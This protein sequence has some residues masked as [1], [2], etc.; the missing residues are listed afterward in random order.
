LTYRQ[1]SFRFEERASSLSIAVEL[2][3]NLMR[4][5]SRYRDFTI[6]DGFGRVM[7]NEEEIAL[8]HE[9]QTQEPSERRTSSAERSFVR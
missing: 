7:L 4:Q 5:E 6:R 8:E 9:R 1:G 2:A 3:V